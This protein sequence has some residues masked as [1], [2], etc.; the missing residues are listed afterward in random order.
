MKNKEKFSISKEIIIAIVV[1]LLTTLLEL[2]FKSPK[3]D[4]NKLIMSIAILV[5]LSILIGIIVFTKQAQ[6]LIK[7]QNEMLV[8][9]NKYQE[10]LIRKLGVNVDIIMY[11]P[12]C[13]PENGFSA[14]KALIKK[15]KSIIALD[16][17]DEETVEIETEQEQGYVEWYELL[18]E[19][20]KGDKIEEYTRFIQLKAGAVNTLYS[21][22]HFDPTVFNHYKTILEI[23][24]KVGLSKNI[25][26]ITCPIFLPRICFIIIDHRYVIWELPTISNDIKFTFDMDLLIEDPN[27]ILGL[28]LE[29]IIKNRMEKQEDVKYLI[30]GKK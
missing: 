19:V 26:L 30:D 21:N 14:Y 6:E 22:N 18:N 7:V 16:Y 17:H 3:W 8:K 4:Q 27:L 2:F 29:S 5:T 28:K 9:T 23:N 13:D 10:E 20:I 15:A 12:T 1:I 25:H 24:K 11:N